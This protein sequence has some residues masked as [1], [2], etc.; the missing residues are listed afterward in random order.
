MAKK[1]I[2]RK[3]SFIDLLSSKI[4]VTGAAII[5]LITVGG[6][7]FEVGRNFKENEKICKCMI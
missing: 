6:A 3:E 5:V 1:T 4:S 2:V 7:S